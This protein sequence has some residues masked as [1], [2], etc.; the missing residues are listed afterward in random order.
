M[1]K[2]GLKRMMLRRMRRPL[3]LRE[4]INQTVRS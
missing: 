1:K 4:V 2:S 3:F